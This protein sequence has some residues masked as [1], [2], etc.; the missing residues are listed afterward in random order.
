MKRNSE[1]TRQRLL[2]SAF[3][4]FYRNGYHRADMERVL[5]DVGVT[6]GA[7]YHH[8]S[9]KRE[10]GYAVIEE[11]L[12]EWI[13]HRWLE[14]LRGEED[15]L[16][17]LADLARWGERWARP[18]GLAMGCPLLTLA[19]ELGGVDEGFRRRLAAIYLEWRD[20]LTTLLSRA[21]QKGLVRS[22]L[23]MRSAA[24]F[25]IGAW[26]GSIGLGK[27]LQTAETLKLCRQ[28][29]EVYLE[30]LRQSGREDSVPSR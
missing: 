26:Q 1:A 5:R 11:V 3:R 13:V 7:L 30:A 9:S 27:S 24:T 14:P 10:L 16:V 20:G 12:R 21:Q 8:F 25:I 15:P 17:G 23:E 6:K 19:Q 4:E 18:E 28:S 29:L 2:A 22:D